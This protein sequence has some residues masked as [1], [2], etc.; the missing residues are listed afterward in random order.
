M[1]FIHRFI[2]KLHESGILT[3]RYQRSKPSKISSRLRLSA[4]IL[5]LTIAL[6]GVLI[7]DF[8]PTYSTRYW[9][10]AVPLFVLI[11]LLLS[12]HAVS[13]HRHFSLAWQE[14]WHW[15]ILLAMVLLVDIFADTGVFSDVLAGIV[16]LLL[17]AFST[18]L[19]GIYFDSMLLIV[20]FILLLCDILSVTFVHFSTVV[21][22]PIIAI[23]A[24]VIVWRQRK[25]LKGK[26]YEKEDNNEES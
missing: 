3:H 20:G 11:N 8:L 12:W 9:F 23:A 6:L 13:K 24:I 17:L 19:A 5:M 14:F 10:Y 16:V 15:L 4:S 18:I 1:Q 26:Q 7:T 2:D 21:M 25:H 22:I